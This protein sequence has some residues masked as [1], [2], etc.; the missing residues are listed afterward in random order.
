MDAEKKEGYVS[1]ASESNRLGPQRLRWWNDTQS[2]PIR[3][4]SHIIHGIQ[5]PR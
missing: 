4:V 1:R 3:G 2:N 5:A